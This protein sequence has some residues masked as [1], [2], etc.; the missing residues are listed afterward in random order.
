VQHEGI[1]IRAQLGDD[2]RHPLR[3]QPGDEATSREAVELGDDDG[4]LGDLASGERLKPVTE[5]SA[6][7][8]A[9]IESPV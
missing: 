7:G 3:H 8:S 2:K 5:A 6:V 9:I 1:C 4:A